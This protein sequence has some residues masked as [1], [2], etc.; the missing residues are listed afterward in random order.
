MSLI[1]MD[2]ANRGINNYT[3]GQITLS[4]TEQ[5]V[6]LDFTPKCVVLISSAVSSSNI[7]YMALD[8]ASNIDGEFKEQAYRDAKSGTTNYTLRSST[9]LTII[10][11]GFTATATSSPWSTTA[12]YVAIG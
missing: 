3:E 10:N 8:I 5:T 4:M 7:N 6:S 1:N 9:T 12:Y 11:N 2:F